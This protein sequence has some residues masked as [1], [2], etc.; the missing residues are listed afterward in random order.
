EAPGYNAWEILIGSKPNQLALCRSTWLSGVHSNDALFIA[1]FNPTVALKLLDEIE[2]LRARLAAAD[3]IVKAARE[4]RETEAF[5][6]GDDGDDCGH[7]V[8]EQA[9]GKLKNALIDY[10]SLGAQAGGEGVK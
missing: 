8:A 1:A 7:D 4:F 2:A 5:L 6:Y 9:Y 3:E 10:D